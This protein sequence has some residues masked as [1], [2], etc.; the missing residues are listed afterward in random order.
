MEIQRRQM[1][2]KLLTMMTAGALALS[3]GGIVCAAE[4]NPDGQQP[5]AQQPKAQQ[6]QAQQPMD[7]P[8]AGG[9]TASQRDQEYLASLK[10]CEPLTGTERSKCIDA[11][12][13]K[14]GQ[15]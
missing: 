3:L 11:A 9:A 4:R 5:K 8:A 10:K 6:P 14:H 1:M 12:R 13:K 15:L 2:S 7:D